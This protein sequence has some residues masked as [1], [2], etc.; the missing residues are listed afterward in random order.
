MEYRITGTRGRHAS[1]TNAHGA[2]LSVG[3]L[4]YNTGIGVEAPSELHIAV[5]GGAGRFIAW[6][7]VDDADSTADARAT[8]FADDALAFDSGPLRG[9]T[10]EGHMNLDRPICVSV[11]VRG[12]KTLRL[13]VEG[14]GLVDWAGARFIPE[15]E[16]VWP[17]PAPPRAEAGTLAPPRH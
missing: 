13:V 9:H 2:P 4:T 5:P 1:Q 15:S 3:G 8:A 16:C 7:G 14:A 6:V 10:R 11:P 17:W 12:V